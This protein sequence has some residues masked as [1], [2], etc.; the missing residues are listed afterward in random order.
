MERQRQL[1]LVS[2]LAALIIYVG[3]DWVNAVQDVPV[4]N[5][6]APITKT[7]P[8]GEIVV[9]VSGYVVRPGVYRV[10]KDTRVMDLI[11]QAGGLTPGANAEAVN[12]AQ[13]LSDGVQVNVPGSVQSSVNSAVNTLNSQNSKNM[14]VN[15]N[16][17]DQKQLEALPGIGPALAERILLYRQNQG[18][19]KTLEELKN[20]SGIGAA[21]Y[22]T[23][24]P[25]ITL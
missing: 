3:Y 1:V 8:T 15:I 25:K 10:I 20:V 22:N 12:M 16:T 18:A 24:K 19:F 6:I 14:L 23:L 4:S 2:L 17:A 5:H 13:I 11:N 21:K 9:Y 7:T